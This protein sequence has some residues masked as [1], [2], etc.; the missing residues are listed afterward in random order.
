[1]PLEKLPWN[2]YGPL[3]V[4]LKRVLKIARRQSGLAASMSMT[5]YYLD[6]PFAA[7]FSQGHGKEHM[8]TSVQTVYFTRAGHVFLLSFIIYRFCNILCIWR[9]G[10]LWHIWL[11]RTCSQA[12]FLGFSCSLPSSSTLE[13]KVD[14]FPFREHAVPWL[15]FA[16]LSCRTTLIA[17]DV[18]QHQPIK[19]YQKPF[20]SL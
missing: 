14:T 10:W 19:T 7:P 13:L 18:C 5:S 12:I 6:V 8:P 20:I 9:I 1:M 17:T 2:L 16:M 11:L 3:C 4:W 15:S